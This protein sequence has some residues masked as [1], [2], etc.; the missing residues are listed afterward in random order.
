M[1]FK[2][3]LSLNGLKC[4][5]VSKVLGITLSHMSQLLNGHRKPT[6]EMAKKIAEFTKGEITEEQVLS[7]EAL[8]YGVAYWK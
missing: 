5:Y 1:T 4:I 8:G 6:P 7:G 3:W 2:D